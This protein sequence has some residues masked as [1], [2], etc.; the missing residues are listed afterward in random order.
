MSRS[1][2]CTIIMT[3]FLFERFKRRCSYLEH[4]ANAGMLGKQCAERLLYIFMLCVQLDQRW[5]ALMPAPDFCPAMLLV[6]ATASCDP[7]RFSICSSFASS[8]MLAHM[9]SGRL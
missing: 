8:R 6:S 3:E 7:L 4:T 1:A 5:V 9:L 2:T